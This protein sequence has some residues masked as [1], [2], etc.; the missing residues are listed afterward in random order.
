MNARKLAPVKTPGGKIF[1]S[2]S[3]N[4]SNQSFAESSIATKLS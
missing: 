1:L 3:G 4:H 2:S